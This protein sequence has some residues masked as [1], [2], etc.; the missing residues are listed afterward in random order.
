V[1][2]L[3]DII[4]CADILFMLDEA[5]AQGVTAAAL[6]RYIV[7]HSLAPSEASSEFEHVEAPITRRVLSPH[8]TCGDPVSCCI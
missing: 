3:S 8:L 1:T 6:A 2:P 4:T 7:A 5:P